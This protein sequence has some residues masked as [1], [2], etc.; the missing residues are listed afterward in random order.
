MRTAP[1]PSND[2]RTPTRVGHFSPCLPPP[3][4]T[5]THKEQEIPQIGKQG[6]KEREKVRD[7]IP[8]CS[9]GETG[10]TWA[11]L[12]SSGLARGLVLPLK[13]DLRPSPSFPFPPS[14]CPHP[15]SI[16]P[17][18]FPLLLMHLQNASK[19][20]GPSLCLKGGPSVPTT[21]KN[22]LFQIL[23]Q[24]FVREGWP[25]KPRGVSARARRTI[26]KEPEPAGLALSFPL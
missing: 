2:A 18:S 26:M 13:G 6:R 20:D 10:P 12:V 8:P 9:E 14:L 15:S 3:P 21:L 4:P 7:A 23:A 1:E 11:F 19:R 25:W 22:S 17:S 16:L 24:P 5:H